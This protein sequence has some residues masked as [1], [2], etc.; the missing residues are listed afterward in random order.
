M[1]LGD[2]PE[3]GRQD[4]LAAR[5]RGLDGG[6]RH[7]RDRRSAGARPLDART[8][9]S[10]SPRA[11]D[12]DRPG[13]H[14][15]DRLRDARPHAAH[16]ALRRGGP[17]RHR[18]RGRR[19]PTARALRPRRSTAGDALGRGAPALPARPGPGPGSTGTAPRR[20]HDRARRRPPAGGARAGRRPA[21]VPGPHGA[22]HHAR[23]HGRRAVPGPPGDAR[24]GSSRRRRRRRGRPDRGACGPLLRCPRA[25]AP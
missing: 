11:P 10:R 8:L 14:A 22:L 15:G 20:A 13:R 12:P 2:R 17:G 18:R 23:P 3:R 16:P 7:H 1:G 9:A 21:Q 24:Q 6:R 19:P 4:D 5:H 25:R